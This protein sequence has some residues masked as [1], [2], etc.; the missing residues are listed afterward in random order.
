MRKRYSQAIELE[1]GSFG[2]NF[3]VILNKTKRRKGEGSNDEGV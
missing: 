1:C 3:N 2:E